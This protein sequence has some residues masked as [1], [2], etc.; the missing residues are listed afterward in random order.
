M[1][2]ER[3]APNGLENRSGR[4]ATAGVALRL[5][6]WLDGEERGAEV[7]LKPKRVLRNDSG[8]IFLSTCLL[9]AVLL[10]FVMAAT[11]S[12]IHVFGLVRDSAQEG[13]SV[14]PAVAGG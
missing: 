8:T 9:Q 1:R 11:W 12:K 14:P 3:V 5:R 7:G 6:S 4:K 2:A 10:S 13:R